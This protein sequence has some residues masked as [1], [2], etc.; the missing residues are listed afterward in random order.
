MD[1]IISLLDGF[2]PR[3]LE[4]H[5]FPVSGPR[6]KDGTIDIQQTDAL[7]TDTEKMKTSILWIQWKLGGMERDALVD[8]HQRFMTMANAVEQMLAHHA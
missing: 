6:K 8:A 4:D 3:V 2:G 5:S 7:L 1:D